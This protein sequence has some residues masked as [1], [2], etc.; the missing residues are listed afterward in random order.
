MAIALE[1]PSR[2]E[3]FSQ[4]K[5]DMVALVPS[6][7]AFARGLCRNRDLADDLAQEAMTRAW[8]ARET[9]IPGSNFK[10]WMFTILRNEFYNSLRKSKRETSLEPEQAERA[11]IQ[12][13]TQENGIHVSDVERTMSRLPSQQAEALWLVAGAGMSYEEAAIIVGTNIGTVKSRV[14]RARET[15][16]VFMGDVAISAATQKPLAS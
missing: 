7:R 8:A 3:D 1:R 5:K 9:Y 6:L 10:A 12:Q 2:P 13:A 15:M 16:R 4:F 11:L 14:S